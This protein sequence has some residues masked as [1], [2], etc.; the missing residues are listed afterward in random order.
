MDLVLKKFEIFEKILFM[1]NGTIDQT[2]WSFLL[3]GNVTIRFYA[4]I[5]R[6]I[7]ISNR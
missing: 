3:D 5:L 1:A 7:L 6:I 4:R 2:A